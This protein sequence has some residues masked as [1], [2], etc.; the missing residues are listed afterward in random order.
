MKPRDDDQYD[1]RTADTEGDHRP[2][3][4]LGSFASF[5]LRANRSLVACSSAR[6]FA[7]FASLAFFIGVVSIRG[8]GSVRRGSVS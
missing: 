7:S 1:D 2:L 4:S 5:A 8:I 6:S 3:A